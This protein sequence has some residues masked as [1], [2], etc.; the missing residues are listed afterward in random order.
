MEIEFITRPATN[1]GAEAFVVRLGDGR[2]EQLRLHD[3]DRVFAIPGLYEEVVQVR[4]E[5]ASPEVLADRLVEEVRRAGE[6]VEALSVLDIGAGNGLV[7]DTLRSHGV[8]G[9][10]VGLDR[11][12][13]AARATR[14]DRPGVYADYLT[15]TLD[16]IDVAEVI[17]R[18]GLTC[19]AGAGAIGGGHIT[20]DQLAAAWRAFPEGAWLAITFH[21]LVMSENDDGLGDFVQGLRSG[22]EGTEVLHFQRFRHRLRMSGEPIYYYVLIARK[23]AAD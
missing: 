8:E 22:R 6:P 7:G 13:A 15:A 10:I 21:E 5:C 2:S 18:S 23:S 16:Q 4:L 19:L 17:A 14:R 9:R 20:R 3:Y 11:E 12:P 1:P